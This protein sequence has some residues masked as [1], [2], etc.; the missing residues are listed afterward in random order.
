M[1]PGT[2]N[3][4]TTQGASNMSSNRLRLLLVSV[5]AVVAISAV[6][7]ASA[8]AAVTCYPVAE[9]KN[10]QLRNIYKVRKKRRKSGKRMGFHR[11][12]G[13]RSRAWRMVRKSQSERNR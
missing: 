13:K 9:E 11:K 12:T 5:M 2:G 10:R 4:T 1:A 7:S 8:S 3:D 6:A